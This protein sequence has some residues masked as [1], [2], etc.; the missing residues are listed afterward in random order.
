MANQ[1]RASHILVAN[2]EHAKELIMKLKQGASFEDLAKQFSKCP[3]GKKGGDLGVFGKGMMVPEFERAAFAL[4]VGKTLE[5]QRFSGC[6]KPKFLSITEKPVRTQF[7]FHV[8][9][10]TE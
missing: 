5:N 7:G 2:E 8:I 1:I 6:Q 10:R 9:K 4:D 3:S